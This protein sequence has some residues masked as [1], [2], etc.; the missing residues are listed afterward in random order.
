MKAL[1]T[2]LIL[3]AFGLSVPA[4]LKEIKVPCYTHTVSVVS[5]GA[6]SEVVSSKDEVTEASLRPFAR[7]GLVLDFAAI[8]LLVFLV[9]KKSGASP[10]V[11]L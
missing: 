5:D 3:L 6:K 4:F 1:L 8:V 9:R 2:I 10:S 11:S 7:I